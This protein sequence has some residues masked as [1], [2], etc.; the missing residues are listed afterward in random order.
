MV[1]AVENTSDFSRRIEEISND[2]V[3]QNARAFNQLMAAQQLAI[4]EVNN[5]V[6]ALREGGT[7]TLTCEADGTRLGFSLCRKLGGGHGGRI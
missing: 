6:D 2:E 4:S 3:G 7:V 1:T 5:A